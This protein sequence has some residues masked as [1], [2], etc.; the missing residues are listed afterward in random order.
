M[1]K[2]FW[3]L[4]ILISLL[5]VSCTTIESTDRPSWIDIVPEIPGEKVF[6]ASG[7]GN[8]EVEAR[9]NAVLSVLE[10]MGDEIGYSLEDKYFRELFSSLKIEDLDRKS[11]V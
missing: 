11:V 5:I 6:V 8:S 7:N 1:K 10:K 9:S 2:A 3:V 4:L